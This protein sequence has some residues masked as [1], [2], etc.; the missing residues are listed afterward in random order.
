MTATNAVSRRAAGGDCSRLKNGTARAVSATRSAKSAKP[1]LELPPAAPAPDEAAGSS[2]ALGEPGPRP[3]SGTGAT[4]AGPPAAATA[5]ARNV[6]PWAPKRATAPAV[7][8]PSG[9]VTCAVPLLAPA[10]AGPLPL[11][12]PGTFAP[13]CGLEPEPAP[14][15]GPGSRPPLAESPMAGRCF[16]TA[17]GSTPERS[18]GGRTVVSA[19]VVLWRLSV[20][21]AREI[22][23][24]FVAVSTTGASGAVAVWTI[25]ESGVSGS[26]AVRRTGVSG[27]V[28]V[29][30]SG[31]SGSVAA[32]TS[33]VSVSVAALTSGVRGSVAVWGPELSGAASV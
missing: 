17:G 23:G 14:A 9:R 12:E 21:G 22:V 11:G 19:L 13:V 10:S 27:A 29:S 8:G 26:V 16:E 2:G 32:S 7:A 31:V 28:T 20:T 3:A 33:G 25:G 18:R 4:E 6:G 15:V 30:T 1:P 24:V 5:A